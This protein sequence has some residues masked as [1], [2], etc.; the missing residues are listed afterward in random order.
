MEKADVLHNVP[1]S[2][3]TCNFCSH[4]AWAAD[5]KGTLHHGWEDAA[6]Q[7]TPHWLKQRKCNPSFLKRGKRKAWG[8]TGWPG[9]PLCLVKS[10][11]TWKIRRSLV[12]ANMA[13]SKA[14][15]AWHIWWPSTMGLQHCWRSEEWLLLS[16]WACAKHLTLPHTAS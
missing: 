1:A 14:N 10:W 4:A 3:F 15:H 8:T 7:W 11:N 13:L 12:T 9:S 16:T 5:G 6:V 2:V